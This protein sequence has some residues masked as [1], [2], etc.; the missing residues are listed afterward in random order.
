[1]SHI[2]IISSVAEMGDAYVNCIAGKLL[3]ETLTVLMVILQWNTLC[4][5]FQNT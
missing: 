2:V 5:V 1:M 3:K 4:L